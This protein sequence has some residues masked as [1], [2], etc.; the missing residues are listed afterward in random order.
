MVPKL[1]PVRLRRLRDAFGA[2]ENVLGAP[3]DKLAAVEGVGRELART[4][5]RWE[6]HVDLAA[7]LER[8]RESGVHVLTAEDPHYPRLLRQIHDP[9]TALYV[10]GELTERDHHGIGVVGSRQAT[11]Y[12]TECARKF[13]YQLAFAGLTVYSGLARGIDTNAH[14]GALAAKGRTVAVMGGGLS[15]IYPPENFDLAQRI[16]DGRGAL[17]SEFSMAVQPDRQTFPM[18]NRIISGACH[19]VLVVEAGERSGALHSATFAADQGRTVFAIPGQIDKPQC[20]GSNRLIQ[21]G[22]KLVMDGGD[23]LEE[24][25]DLF[26]PTNLP[27]AP[28][29]RPALDNLSDLENR[30]VQALGQEERSIDDVIRQTE[31]PAAAVS[32]ALFALELKRV[33]KQLPG[34]RYVVL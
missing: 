6:D 30:L 15:E 32:S 28:E 4:I 20:I 14:L 24:F 7:E 5:S 11:H 31:L 27:A 1:G 34:K 9:P 26:R 18:R 8:I 12:A 2:A 21:Q 10:W 13:G 29:Q 16:A 33:V 17:I 23:I 22:A 3:A 19:G 25:S